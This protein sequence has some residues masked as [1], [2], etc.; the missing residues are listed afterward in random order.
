MISAPR[1]PATETRSRASPTRCAPAGSR[2]P[3]LPA[4]SSALPSMFAVSAR[5][6]DHGLGVL[7]SAWVLAARQ[8]GIRGAWHLRTP[9]ET[10]RKISMPDC[11]H[12]S[13]RIDSHRCTSL[14]AERGVELR[15]ATARC[16]ADG[17]RRSTPR[18]RTT[19]CLRGCRSDRV[20]A[21][22]TCTADGKRL[23]RPARSLAVALHLC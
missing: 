21:L 17:C 6:R 3:V 16:P 15:R 13:L 12:S 1:G 14:L 4:S 8:H 10:A 9:A 18:R 5:R 23:V 19:G 11:F 22:V 7:S 2:A 20:P